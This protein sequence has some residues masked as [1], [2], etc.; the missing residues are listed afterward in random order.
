MRDHDNCSTGWDESITRNVSFFKR[1]RTLEQQSE[2]L[3][4][5]DSLTHLEVIDTDAS[6]PLAGPCRYINQGSSP[7]TEPG[8]VIEAQDLGG[9]S[10]RAIKFTVAEQEIT[11]HNLE[12]PEAATIEECTT[13]EIRSLIKKLKNRKAPGKDGIT[14][15]AI[16]MYQNAAVDH[17]AEIFNACLQHQHFPK[18]WK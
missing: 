15:Q 6:Y 1:Y 4:D 5:A 18:A 7:V 17:L 8:Q 10:V 3:E 13:D 9:T 11:K 16:K 12:E 14:N 2:E